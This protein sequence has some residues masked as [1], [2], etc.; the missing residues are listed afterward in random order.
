MGGYATSHF[1]TYE[2]LQCGGWIYIRVFC[3][4]MMKFGNEDCN[5]F[6]TYLLNLE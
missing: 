4:M 2:E 3:K 6:S 5:L 1:Q